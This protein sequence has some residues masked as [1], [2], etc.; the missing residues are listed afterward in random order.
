MDLNLF[1]TL[2]VGVA[3]GISVIAFAWRLKIFHQLNRPVDRAPAR[4]RVGSGIAYAYTLGMAPWAKESTRRHWLSYMRGVVF[5]LGIF[6][7]LALL[8]ASPWLGGLP[9]FWRIILGVGAGFGAILGLLG[10]VARLVERNLKS[11]STPD[12]YF[13]V[14]LVSLF[15]ASASIWLFNPASLPLFYLISAAMLVYAPFSKIRHCIY[16]AYSRLFYGKVV[17]SRA[18]F[19]HSQQEIEQV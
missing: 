1:S 7:G 9:F 2:S 14:L 13:S 15:L 12:D 5:H 10:F 19:P 16:F 17:G 6:L 18:I 8:L 11:L 4:G 3:L